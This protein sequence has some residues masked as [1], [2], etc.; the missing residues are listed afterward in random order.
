MDI[1]KQALTFI[2]CF[3]IIVW[4]LINLCV[5]DASRRPFKLI[6]IWKTRYQNACNWESF[7]CLFRY[8]RQTGMVL[9][10]VF[11][12]WDRNVLV[13]KSTVCVFGSWNKI[14]PFITKCSKNRH[15]LK[16]LYY[17]QSD[18]LFKLRSKKW[19]GRYLH[20][21]FNDEWVLV[22]WWQ[23]QSAVEDSLRRD[24]R[25]YAWYTAC[26]ALCTAPRSC[27]AFR[28]RTAAT[29]ICRLI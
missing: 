21:I 1:L 14:N 11:I 19:Q 22:H 2:R 17:G 12:P 8:I 24:E 16:D 10:I 6:K 28:G 13:H 7:W 26:K 4:K 9:Q 15:F 5:F 29:L 18:V 25:T 27:S 23:R 20:L 3:V